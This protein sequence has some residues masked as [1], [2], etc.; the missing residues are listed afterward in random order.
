MRTA[1]LAT[2]LAAA[3]VMPTVAQ[4]QTSELRHDRREIRDERRDYQ[5]ALRHGDRRDVREAR[6]DYQDARREYRDDWRDYRRRNPALYRAGRYYGPS[7]YRYRPV[8]AG[9]RFQPAYYGQR[10]WVDPYRYHL[11]RPAAAQ[12]WVR[13]GNDV[14]LV[15]VRSGLVVRSYSGFFY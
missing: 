5:Q 13:Y 10:Y 9:Y 11:P 15:N 1:I 4:A 8:A 12:R 3:T 7:G 14:V 6:R 2:L